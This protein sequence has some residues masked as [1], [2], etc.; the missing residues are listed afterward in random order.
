MDTISH[1]LLLSPPDPVKKKYRILID[2][3]DREITRITTPPLGLNITCKPGCFDCCIHFSVF[4]VEA[5][6]LLDQLKEEKVVLTENHDFCLLLKNKRCS[7][8]D[9]RPIICRT[10]GVPL[11]YI[12]E[13]TGSVEISACHHNFSEE[14]QFIQEEVLFMDSYNRRLFEL[15]RDYCTYCGLEPYTRIPL[16]SFVSD[17]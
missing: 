7:L 6:L 15:N 3:I 10:Q 12:D 11:G 8:Y 9:V 14:Y 2:D 4:A 16:S 13:L 1:E 5:A 17:E